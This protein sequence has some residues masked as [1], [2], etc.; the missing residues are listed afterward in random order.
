VTRPIGSIVRY[1]CTDIVVKI[2]LHSAW[3]MTMLTV[4]FTHTQQFSFLSFSI[5]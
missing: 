5:C 4:Q 2:R 3:D 1:K